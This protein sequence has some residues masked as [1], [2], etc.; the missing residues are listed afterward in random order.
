MP[1]FDE[2]LLGLI[3]GLTEFLPVSS[4]GHLQALKVW[5][6][7]PLAADLSFDVFVHFATLLAIGVYYRRDI[8]DLVRAWLPAE[9][10]DLGTAK[11]REDRR[12]LGYVVVGAV[13]AGVAGLFLKD[14]I[15]S[16]PKDWP[17]CV[18]VFWLIT[19]VGLVSLRFVRGPNE[20]PLGVRAALW[21]GLFQALAILPGIS[22]SG[23]TIIAGVWF[24]C[25][26][27]EVARFSFLCAAPLILGATLLT[28]IDIFRDENYVAGSD[29]TGYLIGGA[30]AFVV[31]YLALR[32][33]LRMLEKGALYWWA[34]YLVAAAGA[35]SGWLWS[36]P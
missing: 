29:L 2:I 34:I 9:R 22:R 30:V 1:Y 6:D 7:S 3:Q 36:R 21:I 31:G 8:Y 17:H 16:L 26:R 13:P 11:A 14:S 15:E 5:L 33:L 19:A 20:R 28:G 23:S 18:S 12:F 4:S 35:Y 32:L 10:D 25:R 24:G 27:E